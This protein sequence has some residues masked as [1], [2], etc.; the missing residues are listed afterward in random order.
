MTGDDAR[1]ERPPP[2]PRPGP[3]RPVPVRTPAVPVPAH[4]DPK[5]FGRVAE[6]GTVFLVTSNGERVAAPGRPV[7]PMPPSTIS[8]GASMTWPP[9]SR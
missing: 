4:S 8:A 7:T 1:T 5:K 3:A 2:T 6:D 9:R